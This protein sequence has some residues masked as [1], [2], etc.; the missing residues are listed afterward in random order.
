MRLLACSLTMGVLI[1]CL[2]PLDSW[3]VTKE[4]RIR[5][6]T[7]TAEDLKKAIIEQDKER[8]LS[9]VNKGIDCIDHMV[10]LKEVKNDLNNTN[11]RF[12]KNLFGP[13]GMSMY[14]RQAKDQKI[15]IGFM[16]VNGRETLDA[17]CFH[18]E[19]SNF[20]AEDWPEI[21]LYQQGGKWGI[22]NSLYDCL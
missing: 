2:L 15:R 5:E 6:L 16:K 18:Y 14:F 10:E 11:S 1:A 19:S 7:A 20:Q 8:I 4:E 12:Y 21:C 22:T 17:A 9:Y 3:A 13:E